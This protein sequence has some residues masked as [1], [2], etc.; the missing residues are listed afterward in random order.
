MKQWYVVYTKPQWELKAYKQLTEQGLEAYC[1]TYTEVRQWSDRKKKLRRPYFIN[2]LF[3]CL[4]ERERN[5]AF[6]SPG[7]LR[8]LFWQGRPAVVR[9]EEVRLMREYLDGERLTDARV[10]RY[11][12]G[13]EVTFARGALKDRQARIEEINR[14]QVRL[15][16][17]ALGYRITA[18]LAD[19]MA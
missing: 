2:Y 15:L 18:R 1:P 7:V 8:Y 11:A 5:R 12:V 19:L 17:P 4:E 3:V 13:D 16:L 9:E 6:A 14:Q 10:E